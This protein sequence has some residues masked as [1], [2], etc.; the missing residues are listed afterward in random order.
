MG[1]EGYTTGEKRR[2]LVICLSRVIGETQRYE[3]LLEKEASASVYIVTF[4]VSQVQ[5][6]A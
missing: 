5:P 1:F 2:Y 4:K 3:Y 6:R